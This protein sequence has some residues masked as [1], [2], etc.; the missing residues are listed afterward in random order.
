MSAN[1]LDF[2][3][4]RLSAHFAALG[5]KPFRAKQVSRWVHQRFAGD[6]AAMTDLSRP[7]RER[8][9]TLAETLAARGGLDVESHFGLGVPAA[10]IDARA[11]STASLA[12][13][14][15]A[16]LVLAALPYSRSK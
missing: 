7:L 14:P 4:P 11:I 1:L 5:E 6:V 10:A 9:A 16:W 3:L 15:S 8:L 12:A 13:Q 2:T